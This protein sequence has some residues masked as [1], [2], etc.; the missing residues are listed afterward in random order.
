MEFNTD[1]PFKYQIVTDCNSYVYND[2]EDLLKN[3]GYVVKGIEQNKNLRPELLGQPKFHNLAGPMWN[4]Y[5]D[6][7]PCIRYELYQRKGY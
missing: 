5:I 1:Q 2:L 6:G 4:A 3:C 7:K